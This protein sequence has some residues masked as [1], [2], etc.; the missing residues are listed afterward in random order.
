M[1]NI[2]A[3]IFFVL[4]IN[5]VIKNQNEASGDSCEKINP[6]DKLECIDATTEDDKDLDRKCCYRI[7]EKQD[8]TKQFSCQ[9][10]TE[11]DYNDI[12]DFE[13]EELRYNTNLK[14]VK[15]DCLQTFINIKMIICLICLFLSYY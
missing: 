13:E 14:L 1:F 12:E 7:D 2:R 10:L 3:I 15:L 8:G 5:T 4:L 11:D 6:S 9:L